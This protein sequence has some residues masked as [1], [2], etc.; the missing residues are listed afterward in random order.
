M[1]ILR[2]C[3]G[4]SE[5]G[6]DRLGIRVFSLR[7]TFESAQPLTFYGDFD[8]T[9]NTLTYVSHGH[10]INVRHEGAIRE[11]NLTVASRDIRY[12]AKDVSRRFR[13][14]DRMPY[15]YKKINTDRHM[16]LAIDSYRGMR[17]TL[18]DPWET[19][20]V[21]ILS[22][23]NNVKRIRLIT[24]AL[25][26]RF[27][28]PVTD[29]F[30]R[31]IARGLPESAALASASEADLEAC[32]AG[33]R[34]KYLRSA[35]DYFTHNVDLDSLNGK[36]YEGIKEALMGADGI[37]DKVADCIAL[38]AYGKLESFPI[39]TWI[40]RVMERTYF[41][42]KKTSPRRIHELAEEKWGKLAGY[43]QQ[44]IYHSGRMSGV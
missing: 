37:G 14:G 44:Y 32:G 40:Q 17:L 12:A 18:N 2:E 25:T 5:L 33:F 13:L 20:L 35:A 22:Q 9:S 31:E 29:D 43:A 21:F 10:I 38:M 7:H 24:K 3:M 27:G 28:V 26:A 41:R 16:S 19:S 39:D 34:A 11:G 8:G 23:F 30:G 4:Y 6:L 42:G 15:I 1:D 36:S